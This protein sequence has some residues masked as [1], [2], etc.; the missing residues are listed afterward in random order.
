[1]PTHGPALSATPAAA[2][3]G[4]AVRVVHYLNHVSLAA[5]GVTRAAIDLLEV[6][7]GRGADVTLL[8]G[9]AED[10]PADWGQAGRPRVVTLGRPGL[11]GGRL[12]SSQLARAA[13][14][15]AAAD[16]LHLHGVW[17]AANAQLAAV[18]HKLRRPYLISP[19]GMLDDWS[20]GQSSAKRLKKE[21]YLR[22]IGRRYVGRAALVH[23]TAEAE[24]RQAL[25]RLRRRPT[26][27][28][29]LIVD[30]APF[31]TLPGP[32]EARKLLP[33][34]DAATLLF[35]SRVHPKKGLDKLLDALAILRQDGRDVRLAVGGAGEAAYLD[36]LRQQTDRLGVADRVAW[37]GLVTGTAKISL[38]ESADLFVL[39]TS[40]E[41]FGLVLA[42]SMA[43]GTPVVTTRGT[44]IWREL[45]A[46]GGTI[47]TAEP[48]D[49]AAAIGKLLDDPADLQVRGRRGRAWVFD[50]LDPD[51]LGDAYLDA[52]RLT[53]ETRRRG[54]GDR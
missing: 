47:T 9:D 2:A 28:L 32:A 21:L 46:A 35:L 7:A 54:E 14:V 13:E 40:Q 34:S 20:M 10:V 26:L 27:V 23:L 38:Y 4:R 43:C 33:A 22:T 6:L 50:T 39:P 44:D 52:Y 53:T 18:A 30:L 17:E 12:G 3:S 41:N 49:L 19:H 51:R 1:M 29:P 24:R 11:R 16:A 42:E 15:L 37:L 5:G 48:A 31:R 25:P 8:T 45:E 36:Q